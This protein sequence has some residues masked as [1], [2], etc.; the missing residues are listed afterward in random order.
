MDMTVLNTRNRNYLNYLID[1]SRHRFADTLPSRITVGEA[2]VQISPSE[3][4]N[5]VQTYV[6]ELDLFGDDL[7]GR[8][9]QEVFAPCVTEAQLQALAGCQDLT[10]ETLPVYRDIWEAAY[11]LTMQAVEKDVRYDFTQNIAEALKEE[12]KEKK[13]TDYEDEHEL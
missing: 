2:V 8:P 13:E 1:L 7:I 10:A 9:L 6:D 11:R 4:Y 5:Y 12:G 3:R